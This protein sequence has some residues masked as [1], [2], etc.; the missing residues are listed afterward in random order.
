MIKLGRLRRRPLVILY[1]VFSLVPLIALS[2]LAVLISTD[3]VTRRANQSLT[4]SASMSAGY[5]N[6][7]ISSLAG[8]VT[9]YADKS[10]I[11][12][13]LARGSLEP[14]DRPAVDTELAQLDTLR[15]GIAEIRLLDSQG[16]RVDA[17]PFQG[18]PSA[19]TASAIRSWAQQVRNSNQTY[20]SP[21]YVSSTYGSPLVTAV[22]APVHYVG[23]DGSHGPLLGILA[24]EYSVTNVQE[25]SQQI[26]EAQ[27][28]DITIVDQHGTV[29]AEPASGEGADVQRVLITNR[30]KQG[31]VQTSGLLIAYAPVRF[32]SWM[33]AAELPV[34]MALADVNRLRLTVIGFAAPLAVVLLAG[35]WLLNTTLRFWE[36]AEAEVRRLAAIDPLTGIYNR[37]SW[38]EHLERELARA[39]R[40]R[41]PLSLLMIDLDH[42]KRFNDARG[43]PAGDQLLAQTATVWRSMIRATDILARYGGEEFAIALPDCSPDD[44]VLIADRLRSAMP[45][46]Q[47][48]S[49]GVACWDG[50][51]AAAGLVARADRALYQAKEQGRN[52]VV[53][54]NAEAA[55]A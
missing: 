39:R 33:V 8:L 43:H 25:F 48:C 29:V 1:V 47:T 24:V 7:Q 41:R 3:A 14:R 49:A 37:R 19:E 40:E 2:S 11:T 23:G 46:G 34:S 54:A 20:I 17:F 4:L 50:Q 38:D 21:V 51:E 45:L 53:I 18:E 35:A 5:V 52:R 13:A 27:G 16:M 32:T 28:V 22:A 9:A 55:A 15:P 12:D 31:S 30:L 10:E 26:A 6:E 42:F 36:R 44:A